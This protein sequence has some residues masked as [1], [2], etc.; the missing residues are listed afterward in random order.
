MSEDKKEVEETTEEETLETNEVDTEL[1]VDQ[2]DESQESNE[3]EEESDDEGVDYK[4][5]LE[6]LQGEL[7]Q[8]NERI[9]KQDKKILKLKQRFKSEDNEEEEVEEETD[10]DSVVA[11]KVQEQMS[12]F[13]EDTIDDEINKV[14]TNED[15]KKL[16]RYYFDNRI[17]KQGWSKKEI[18]DYIADAKVLA[19]RNKVLSQLKLLQKKTNSDKTASKPN[20]TGTPPKKSTVKITEYDK[21]MAQK[22]FN[23]DIKKWIKYK[24]N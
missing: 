1:E 17:V 7:A 11:K 12:N 19:N 22:F 6:R 14:S 21:K 2:S 10:I 9:A 24:S 5:E 8:K 16:I 20:F 13:V 15:E 23:G 3:S 18:I 4:S